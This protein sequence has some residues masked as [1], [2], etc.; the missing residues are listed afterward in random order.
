MIVIWSRSEPQ[1]C[2]DRGI[3]VLAGTSCVA[4]KSRESTHG[5]L[6]FVEDCNVHQWPLEGYSGPGVGDGDTGST[7]TLSAGPTPAGV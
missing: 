6:T 1:R 5:P 2:I 7:A 3:V 4:L